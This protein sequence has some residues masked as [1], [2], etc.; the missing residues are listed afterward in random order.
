MQLDVIRTID[1]LEIINHFHPRKHY[2]TFIKA[3]ELLVGKLNKKFYAML[4]LGI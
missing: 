4:T 2:D 1:D 3:E